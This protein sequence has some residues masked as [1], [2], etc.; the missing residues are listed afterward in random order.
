MFDGLGEFILG[1]LGS[2]VGT[3]FLSIGG[4]VIGSYY[5][6]APVVG[7]GLGAVTGMFAGGAIGVLIGKYL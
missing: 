2:V 3:L 7:C 5:F 6:A 4:C 1:L